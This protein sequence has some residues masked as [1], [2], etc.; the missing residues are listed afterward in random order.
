VILTVELPRSREL[1]ILHRLVTDAKDLGATEIF[2]G[3]PSAHFYFFTTQSTAFSGAIHSSVFELLSRSV[4]HNSSTQLDVQTLFCFPLFAGR[5]SISSTICIYWNPPPKN[6]APRLRLTTDRRQ[7][8]R[9]LVVEDDRKY[10]RFLS[11]ALSNKGFQIFEAASGEEALRISQ[12]SEIDL[13]ISDLHMPG[14]GGLDLITSLRSRS[15]KI[16]T[17]IL[18][19]EKD[20]LAQAQLILSGIDAFVSKTSDPAILVAWCRRLTAFFEEQ[21]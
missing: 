9:L 12:S 14:R 5:S 1:E 16:P 2:I 15:S 6:P 21:C 19:S 18:S 3:Y 11:A 4:G 10:R 7:P 20:E 13:I 8:P 17:I